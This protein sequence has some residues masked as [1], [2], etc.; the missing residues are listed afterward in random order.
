MN[1]DDRGVCCKANKAKQKQ[2]GLSEVKRIKSTF[3]H[4]ENSFSGTPRQIVSES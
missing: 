3:M 2:N 1:A 4:T